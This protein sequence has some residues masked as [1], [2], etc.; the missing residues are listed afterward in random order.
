MRKKICL[1]K[2]SIFIALI[3]I[4]VFG[5]FFITYKVIRQ[6]LSSQTKAYSP[7]ILSCLT[8]IYKKSDNSVKFK[9]LRDPEEKKTLGLYL[10][11]YKYKNYYLLK[12]FKKDIKKSLANYVYKLKNGTFSFFSLQP[13]TPEFTSQSDP[14]NFLKNVQKFIKMCVAIDTRKD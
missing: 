7:L 12:I 8:P 13:D 9:F 2:K 10:Y 4:V 6:N 14:D 1:S 3:F 11:D 5:T